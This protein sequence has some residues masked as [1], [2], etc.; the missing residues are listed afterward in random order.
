M[1]RKVTVVMMMLVVVYYT[2]PSNETKM[3]YAVVQFIIV[4]C[5]VLYWYK[6]EVYYTTLNCTVL[7]YTV[8]D[9]NE[10]C[11]TLETQP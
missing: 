4:D 10:T 6:T 3:L 9:C 1:A 8:V 2:G 11:R 5:T 7:S